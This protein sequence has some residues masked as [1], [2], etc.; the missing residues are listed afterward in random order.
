[1]IRVRTCRQV[2]CLQKTTPWITDQVR[3]D[4][5]EYKFQKVLVV[6]DTCGYAESYKR[7]LWSGVANL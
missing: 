2:L 4:N 7:Q 6:K 5:T 3:N 1:M